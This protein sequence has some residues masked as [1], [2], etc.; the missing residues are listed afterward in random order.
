MLPRP[1]RKPLDHTRTGWT[2]GSG[3]ETML[4]PHWLARFDDRYADLGTIHHTFFV[5]EVI[6]SP[7]TATRVRTHAASF[8]LAYKLDPGL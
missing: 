7:V 6:Q 8:G 2:L 4:A 1:R 3:L 5:S